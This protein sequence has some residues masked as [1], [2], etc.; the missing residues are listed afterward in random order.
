M[1]SKLIQRI[2][3]AGAP[4][5]ESTDRDGFLSWSGET[6]GLAVGIYYGFIDLRDWHG[7]PEDYYKDKNIEPGH[8]PKF[9]YVIGAVLRVLC[10]VALG[11]AISQ[12][13]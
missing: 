12:F 2:K 9:G 10:Y 11:G 4:T 6:H 3:E 13:L 7:L 5:E 1:L 8:Y